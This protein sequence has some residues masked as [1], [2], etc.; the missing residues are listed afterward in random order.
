MKEDV[1]SEILMEMTGKLDTGQ[2][3][4][5]KVVL[6]MKLHKFEVVEKNTE[7]ICIDRSYMYYLNKFLVRKKSEGKSDKTIMQYR[8][9]LNML[10]QSLNKM[11][12]EIT[13]E[14][15]FCYLVMYKRNREVSNGYLDHIRLVFSS[16]FGWLN[17]KGHISKN[18][19]RGLEPIKAEKKIKKPLTEEEMELL[20]RTCEKKRDLALIEFLYSTGMRVSE[21]IALNRTDINFTE[22]EVIVFGKG[23]KERTVYLNVRSCMHLQEYIHNR[24]DCSKALFVSIKAPHDRLTVAGVEDIV[25][26]L[27][28]Q[29]GIEKVHPHRFR[30]TMATNALKK[31]MPLEEVKE[32][33]GHTKLDTTMIY[34]TVSKENVKFSHQKYMSA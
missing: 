17:A 8:L 27:G 33:L 4:E 16:F 32:I 25:K 31:G 30:R 21:L 13:E 2:L 20:R 19:A 1:I 29:V 11:I 12:T 18:P 9:H 7:L 10:L 23:S 5:L 3:N 34:C 28:K 15:L 14:D 24:T 26:K 22:K 6:H